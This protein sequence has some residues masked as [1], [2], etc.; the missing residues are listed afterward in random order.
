MCGFTEYSLTFSEG[1]TRH[2]GQWT[3]SLRC[4]SSKIL[5]LLVAVISWNIIN[6]NLQL[7]NQ[8]SNKIWRLQ[9]FEMWHHI[10]CYIDVNIIEEPS[11]A[12]IFFYHEYRESRFLWDLLPNSSDYMQ[13]SQKTIVFILFC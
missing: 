5:L 1:I 7:Q 9:S 6:S 11:S 4:A 2:G 8:N 10:L 3:P 13:S 12:A